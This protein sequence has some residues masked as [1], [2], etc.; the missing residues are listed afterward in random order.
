MLE[1]TSEDI[2]RLTDEQ[3]RAVVAR[4]CEAELRGR[5]QSTTHVTWGGDQN[6]P[7]GGIDVRVA[8]PAD[9]AIDGFVLR[10]A[11]GFQVKAQDMSAA[12]ITAEMRPD[13]RLRSSI[14]SLADQGGG[15]VIVSSQG[16]TADIAL[17]NRREAMRNA[18]ADLQN[19]DALSVEFYDR[20]RIA[21]WVRSHDGLIPLVRAL[22]GRP[23]TGWQSYGAWAPA[24]DKIPY[25]Q[26]DALRL[27]HANHGAEG[28]SVVQGI[29]VI[30]TKLREP[31]RAIRL[32][33]LS[34]VGK[35]RLVQALFEQ[36]VGTDSLDPS[37]AMY[38]NVADGPD[39]PPIGMAAELIARQARV[40]LVVD[41]CPS[42]LHHRLAEV[43][44]Q[45]NSSL[46]LLTIEYDIQDD[47]PEG[48]DVFKMEPS[49]DALIESLILGRFT[50]ISEID[51]K[52][53]AGF[54]GGNARIAIALASTV[55]QHE[56]LA[57]LTDEDLFRRLFRQGQGT[58]NIYTSMHRYV[59]SCSLFTAKA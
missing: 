57:G 34:G 16:S 18:L 43:C 47:T 20:T 21:S 49:S 9:A 45:G 15:Y 30:R 27:R 2:S 13:G 44:R 48:T 5:G 31:Q 19:G 46:S 24:S 23:V 38:T 35:T 17:I 3:L 51:A 7:D 8:L 39:P 42:E 10:P 37:I 14:Q 54:S 29:D 32:V 4:L 22:V 56:S 52:S 6:A 26:D 53:I 1:I 12:A 25:L 11:T 41:N 40:I 33:G 59:R 28:V 58:M 55:G 36:N 50:S